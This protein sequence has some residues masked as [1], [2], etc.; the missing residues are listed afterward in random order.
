[1]F[2]QRLTQAGQIFTGMAAAR[3]HPKQKV[4]DL[5]KHLDLAG[6][7][8][9]YASPR[10]YRKT[11]PLASKLGLETGWNCAIS[12]VPMLEAQ[13]RLFS[14]L[15]ARHE[16]FAGGQGHNERPDLVTSFDNSGN[17]HV[18]IRRRGAAT[19]TGHSEVI[20]PPEAVMQSLKKQKKSMRLNRM[21]ID[22][23]EVDYEDD[24]DHFGDDGVLTDEKRAEALQRQMYDAWDIR[25]RLP[26]GIQEIRRHLEETDDVPLLVSIYTDATPLS[27]C[28]MMRIHQENGET[29]AALGS[30]LRRQ[31][32]MLWNVVDIG[33][34]VQP[35]ISA[36][37]HRFVPVWPSSYLHLIRR[38][39]ESHH[40]V[41]RRRK[42]QSA[43][44]TNPD[45]RRTRSREQPGGH[46][47][48]K[49]AA[50]EHNQYTQGIM[51]APHV[52]FASAITSL[53]T[54]LDM[55]YEAKPNMVRCGPDCRGTTCLCSRPNPVPS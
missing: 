7:R 29:V 41:H 44:S 17:L 55:P 25:A 19:G 36:L 8:F 26:H 5:I 9:I 31:T 49:G 52:A 11:K 39:R 2:V 13:A 18:T 47:H 6:I 24:E 40:H 42:Q 30:L 1:M 4:Q 34:G 53:T 37:Q 12:L 33:L 3:T 27:L 32:P 22:K 35:P 14:A 48:G 46:S 54:V 50:A 21:D 38:Y 23:T 10:S 16:A 51:L 28:A 20:P 45:P 15:R 43:A